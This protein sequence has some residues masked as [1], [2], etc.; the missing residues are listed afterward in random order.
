[1]RRLLKATGRT[2]RNCR[3]GEHRSEVLRIGPEHIGAVRLP[4]VGNCQPAREE[5]VIIKM[6]DILIIVSLAL[7]NLQDRH[8]V[9]AHGAQLLWRQHFLKLHIAAA[10]DSVCASEPVAVSSTRSIVIYLFI[11]ARGLSKDEMMN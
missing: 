8:N 11:C 7:K 6:M 4:A 3:T 10:H 5:L 1:M 2:N 9:R